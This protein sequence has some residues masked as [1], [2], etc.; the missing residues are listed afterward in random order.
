MNPTPRVVKGVVQRAL[1]SV[2]PG[3]APPCVPRSVPMFLPVCARLCALLCA[4]LASGC[5]LPLNGKGEVA[6]YDFGTAAGTR[7]GGTRLRQPLL[8]YEVS[9][10]AWM[11]SAS[12]HYRLAYRDASR[13]QAYAGS[14]WVMP[15]AALL[16]N[17]LRQRLAGAGGGVILPTDGLRAPASLRVELDEFTQ[18]FDAENRS[19]AV[20]RLRASL[21]GS[22]SLI[23]QKA[24]GVDKAAAS[25]D[26]EGGVRALTAA[27]DEVL[28][29]LLDWVAVSMKK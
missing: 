3:A 28:E 21:V 18:V 22:R 9:G 16:T 12:I 7:A 4:L 15:P 23:A 24:F 29:Q 6:A 2:G 17:R 1:R 13:P 5:S 25:Q 27:S 10:P 14:R 11:D 19:R 8:V 26:A 20:V